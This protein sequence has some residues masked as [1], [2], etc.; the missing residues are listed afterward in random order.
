MKTFKSM[1]FKNAED[2]TKYV[3]E[4]SNIEVVSVTEAGRFSEGFYLFFYEIKHKL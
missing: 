3:N 2:L 1:H 4:R